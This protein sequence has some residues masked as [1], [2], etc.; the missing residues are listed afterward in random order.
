MTLGPLKLQSIHK[1]F[2][3]RS[4]LRNVTATIDTKQVT[5]LVGDNGAGKTTLLSII[6]GLSRPTS[7]QVL[8]GSSPVTDEILSLIHI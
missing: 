1:R 6:A 3:T 7:G 5:V 8:F 4:A 2:G